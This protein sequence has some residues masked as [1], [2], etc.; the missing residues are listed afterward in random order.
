ML[1]DAGLWVVAD[2]AA[3]LIT[4]PLGR[5]HLRMASVDAGVKQARWPA[6]HLAAFVGC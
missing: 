1:A 4:L 5:L 2:A 3:P 6:R